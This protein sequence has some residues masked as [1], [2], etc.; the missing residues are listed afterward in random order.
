M[1][2]FAACALQ[3]IFNGKEIC[4]WWPWPLTLTF[5]LV[6]ARN[7]ACLPCKFGTN[8]FSRSRDTWFTNKNKSSAVAEMGDRGHNRHGPK[9]GGA[10]VPLSWRV[11]TPSNTMS[12]GPSSVYFPTKWYLHPYSHLATIHIN[13]NWGAVP[14]SGQLR[15]HLT[16][17]RL[18]WR[19]PPYQVASWS[20]QPFDH[21]R[22]GPEIGWGWVYLFSCGSWVLIEH[23]VA[24]AKAYLHTVAS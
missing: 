9:R 23:E 17:C 3:C 22:H 5:K 14:F 21:N 16:Q 2:L 15:P 12:P 10:A 20:I 19:L 24:W 6:W 7:Q 1:T 4:P 13:Q 18:G 8:V 11:G